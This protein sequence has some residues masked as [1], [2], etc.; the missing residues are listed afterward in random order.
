MLV[1]IHAIQKDI[2]LL[3][4]KQAQYHISHGCLTSTRGSYQSYGFTFADHKTGTLKHIFLPCR[5]SPYDIFYFKLFF[6]AQSFSLIFLKTGNIFF[7]ILYLFKIFI[8]IIQTHAVVD[9]T[10]R[11]GRKSSHGGKETKSCQSYRTQPCNKITDIV[12]DP[13]PY[14]NYSQKTAYTYHFIY[15]CRD[16][17]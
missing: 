16:A 4:L 13:E 5:I 15:I 17:V 3:R 9:H 7:I 12:Y 14:N 11:I 8:H 2:T 10:V 6:K 1:N